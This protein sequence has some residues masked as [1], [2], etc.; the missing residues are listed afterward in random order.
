VSYIA[1]YMN[2][3]DYIILG[4]IGIS[5][6]LSLRKGFTLEAISLATWVA[7]YAISKPF[8]V[9]LAH[10]LTDY[11]DPPSARQPVAFA[12]LFIS[13]LIVGA[14]I[15][16]VSKEIV[17]ASGLSAPDRLLGMC[18]GAARGAVIIIFCISMVS[19]LTEIPQDPWWNESVV[20]PHLLLVETW[21]TD[22]GNM[23]WNK[24]MEL[25]AL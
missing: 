13:T 23:A 21:T 22:M 11:I 17:S 1:N 4:I 5:S 7:A 14:L 9:P 8:S 10:L 3:A 19:R 12:L 2:I 25:S 15:K 6:L 24:V 18:F 20:I 16:H